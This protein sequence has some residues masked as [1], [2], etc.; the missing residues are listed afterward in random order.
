MSSLYDDL[1]VSPNASDADIRKAWKQKA[2]AHHPDHGGDPEEF[3]KVAK[4][5]EVLSVPEKREYY[6]RTG[7]QRY[8]V[9]PESQAKMELA[10]IFLN[11]VDH[12]V[13]ERANYRLEVEKIIEANR[14][15]ILSQQAQI[16]LGI[17]KRET[18]LKKLKKK[19]NAVPFLHEALKGAITQHEQAHAI[20]NEKLNL[21]DR[22][23]KL[24]ND[25]YLDNEV[26]EEQP[27]ERVFFSSGPMR[28][29]G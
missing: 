21:L 11:L 1:G 6:N 17:R 16:Q 2:K 19:K 4:A 29:G 5:Y 3:K 26:E 18:A 27:F 13:P 9:D 12:L 20:G 15:Q 24:L 8:G 14:T 23:Q 22:M 10:T 25:N 7:Q 28:V